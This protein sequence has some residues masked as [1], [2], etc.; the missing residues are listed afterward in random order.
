[1]S[2]WNYN[3]RQSCFSATILSFHVFLPYLARLLAKRSS[4]APVFKSEFLP[5][6]LDKGHTWLSS[7][8]GQK[9]WYEK[10]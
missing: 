10:I 2:L 4:G 5:L 3:L 1:M 7:V 6:A 9:E 8:T